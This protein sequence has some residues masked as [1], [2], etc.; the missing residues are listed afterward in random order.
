[1][2]AAT[3]PAVVDPARVHAHLIKSSS[4]DRAL[5]NQLIT[6]YS[7]SSATI[8]DALRLFR[9]LPFAP[10]PI[11]WTAAVSALSSDPVAALRLF[12]SML[13][14]P[15][16]PTQATLS[17]LLKSL[18]LS[19]PPLLSAALQLHSLSLKLALSRL[20]FSGTALVAFYSKARRPSDALKAF[21]DL[22]HKD[23]VCYAAAIV[24]MAQ[25]H[26]PTCAFSLFA[27]MRVAGVASTVYS[28][29]GALRAAAH[30]AALEQAR[31]VHAHAIIAG[32]EPDLVVSTA[33]V[34]AYGKSGL[35]S[36]A[37]MVFD[38]LLPDA[39][40]VTWNAMLSAY[41]Q[42]GDSE[43]TVKLFDE[44]LER[45]IAPDDFSFLA[46]LTA[47]SNAGLVGEAERWIDLMGS[48]FGMAPSLEHYN[49]L[50]GAMARVGRLEDA[51]R[52]VLT[53]P[54]EPDAAVWRTL[55]SG[56]VVHGAADLATTVGR[57]LLEL[58]PQ[59]DSAYVMLA[60]I[61]LAAG[62]KDDMAKVWR[63]MRDQ[64]VKK[65]GGRSWI[66]VRGEVHAFIA[67]DRMHKNATD[68][69]AKVVELM[70]EAKKLGYEE[71]DE[72]LWHHSERL[73][74]AFG[75]LSGAA[76]E[77]KALRVVKN[78]RI[79]GD[80]HEFFKYVTRVIQ[81]EIVVRDVNRY[82]RLQHGC[83]TCKDYW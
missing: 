68:I 28:V 81:R 32:L 21:D 77:G 29:S 67:G 83:C 14:G 38:A 9:R 20:P 52:L 35:V 75:V 54:F 31:V 63:E 30:L 56:C 59:D 13:R 73:A 26:R 74:V 48:S 66:E 76:P 49:C 41:A 69:Y 36:D 39:N 5:Y 44:M 61:Y 7:R 58:D 12:L 3:A 79:C 22:P 62:R 43:S 27:A 19:S 47:W 51:E 53:M 55:L 37:R 50:V 4:D 80:C 8:P 24:G 46:V 78:L 70:E 11:S 16:R 45:K 40:L 72:G 10:T 42:Q 82:H 60:N 17:S 71:A 25:N 57:R 65:E 18:S 64:G 1:M 23:E 33:L 34:D 6:L 2:L 15:S